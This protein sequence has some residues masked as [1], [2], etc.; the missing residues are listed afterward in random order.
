MRSIRVEQRVDEVDGELGMRLHAEHRSHLQHRVRAVAGATEH[1]G[2]FRQHRD[3]ILMHVEQERV[4]GL[5]R[6]DLRVDRPDA[7]TDGRL[8]R[9]AAD[10][11]RQQLM[12]EADADERRVGGA[13]V[14]HESLQP[15]DPLGVV[16]DGEARAG[17]EPAVALVGR[18]RQH[19]VHRV[20]RH[21]LDAEQVREHVGVVA[22]D[23]V[24]P[25]VDVVALEQADAH[26]SSVRRWND[27]GRVSA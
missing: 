6:V 13:D 21:E 1:D 9:A 26:Y 10:R 2:A 22:V 4:V 27:F 24:E 12:A 25:V 7:P 11:M 15:R 5:V 20:V 16:V 14:A 17:R 8:L 19:A 23:G 18:R 3:L